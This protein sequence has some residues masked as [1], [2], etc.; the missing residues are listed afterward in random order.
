MKI[1]KYCYTNFFATNKINNTQ[2]N[3]IVVSLTSFPARINTVFLTIESIFDQTKKPDKVVLW[4][5]GS[6]FLDQKLPLTLQ[7]L[8][9][10]GLEIKF[11]TENYKSYKK[12]I[13]A[14]S[15]FESANIITID[16]DIIYPESFVEL[17]HNTHL[18]FPDCIVGNSCKIIEID[19]KTCS[20]RPYSDWEKSP[21][22]HM[23][24]LVNFATGVRGILYPSKSL[25]LMTMQSQLFLELSP[26]ADD[27]W[28][29]AMSLLNLV[30]VVKAENDGA[31]FHSIP[32]NKR[33]SLFNTNKF[34]NDIQIKQVFDY[35]ELNKILYNT[36]IGNQQ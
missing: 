26:N 17:L 10:R 21:E 8:V 28:F 32:H 18:K 11:V 24:S 7:R 15:E 35:F 1:L 27:V 31:F 12:L 22:A 29:K 13:Y 16:D 6:E 14:L 9:K 5:S 30:K 20:M 3:G 33:K 25:P 34:E 23:P 36:H 19:E 4:L 2:S